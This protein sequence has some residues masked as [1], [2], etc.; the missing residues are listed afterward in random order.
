[1]DTA[2]MHLDT[3]PASL[4]PAYS[5]D[6][7]AAFV[8]SS[9]YEPLVR[10][11]GSGRLTPGV[12]AEMDVDAGAGTVRMRLEP[13][14]WSDGQPLTAQDVR[15]SW[16]RLESLDGGSFRS[17]LRL[18]LGDVPAA[19]AVRVVDPLTLVV[20]LQRGATAF[21]PALGAQ[22]LAPVRDT[23][24]PWATTLGPYRAVDARLGPTEEI[25]LV[26]NDH[27][28][29]PGDRVDRIR[30]DIVPDANESLDIWLAG[31]CDVTCNTMFPFDR[32]RQENV[33]PHLL[34]GPLPLIGVVSVNP[35][36]RCREDVN[37]A[38]LN[39]TVPR[40]EIAETL[41][42]GVVPMNAYWPGG[43]PPRVRESPPRDRTASRPTR[44]LRLALSPFYPNVMVCEAISAAWRARGVPVELDV[45]DYR[46]LHETITTHDLTYQIWGLPYPKQEA[47]L[48]SVNLKALGA[49]PDVVRARQTIV[50]SGPHHTA[51]ADTLTSF[52]DA[53]TP[54]LPVLRLRSMAA[55][56]PRLKGLSIDPLGYPDFS[57]LLIDPVAPRPVGVDPRG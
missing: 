47:H 41:H 35:S 27:H 38:D 24:T 53:T 19:R 56:A 5:N 57:R 25:H 33:R 30:L 8:G 26:A 9:M 42:R 32:A 15:Q 12:V 45:V 52:L 4:D 10:V 20:S 49:G 36:L 37:L 1:M 13:L 14:L 50:T 22:A 51:A 18:L 54:Y 44:P 2:V 21:L 28:P 29:G 55:V 3:A 7:V 6:Y 23:Q 40:D 31:G 17:L 48:L 43:P 11:S 34:Q 16:M 46:S 39:A